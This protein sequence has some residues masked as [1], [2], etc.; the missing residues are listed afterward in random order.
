MEVHNKRGKKE[1]W[2]NVARRLKGNKKRFYKYIQEKEQNRKTLLSKNVEH[3][4]TQGIPYAYYIFYS[5]HLTVKSGFKK[6]K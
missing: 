1:T 6:V 4:K 3:A 2:N 5:S